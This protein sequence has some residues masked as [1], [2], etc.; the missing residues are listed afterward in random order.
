VATSPAGATD[1]FRAAGE[2]KILYANSQKALTRIAVTITD[3]IMVS[4]RI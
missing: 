3:E 1:P 2:R 4:R